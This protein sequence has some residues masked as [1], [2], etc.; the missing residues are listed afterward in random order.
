MLEIHTQDGIT[1]IRMAHGKA[2]ALDLEFCNGLTQA[3]TQAAKTARAIVL[4]GTGRIFSA[5]VDLIRLLKEGDGYT[6]DFLLAMDRCF[7]VLFECERPVVG[8]INGHAI[9]G[10]CIL[11]AACDWRVMADQGATI[12]VPELA[13]GVP[14]PVTPLEIVRSACGD[15][16]TQ[17]LA[18]GCE[19][20]APAEALR[21]GLVHALAPAENLAQAALEHARRFANAPPRAF[22]L[23]KR[24]LR[25]PALE[26]MR[27]LHDH[28]AAVAKEWHS[29]EV[30]SAIA[31]FVERTLKK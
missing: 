7:R 30:R 22:A 25:A 16:L 13:V 27:T 3:I 31:A 17:R 26:R 14:F 18:L 12:G 29:P 21:T 23:V 9:A 2:S 4:T 24:Q 1:T 5:G 11:A 8:A 19:N 6:A 20:L 15:A 28:D 10:G